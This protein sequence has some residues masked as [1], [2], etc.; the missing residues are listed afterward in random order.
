[1]LISAPLLFM[2]CV[3]IPPTENPIPIMTFVDPESLSKTLIIMLPGMGDRADNFVKA[4]FVDTGNRQHFDVFAVDAHSGYYTE[5]NLIPRLHEDIIV[6]AKASGYEN[7]WLLGVSM[8]GFGSLLYAEEYPDEIGG[9]I[10]LAPFLG[11]RQLI[12]GIEDAGGLSAWKDES[13]RFKQYE[14][15]IW[16]WLK[17]EITSSDGTPVILGFGHSDR[18]AEAYGLLVE[19]L[20]P[21]HVYISDGGHDWKTWETLWTRI[22]A[23][24]EM[25]PAN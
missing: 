18:M 14:V 5:R 16:T 8:G 23:N 2:S 9:V 3:T 12:E 7:I 25:P 1:M 4:G 22:A 24:I 6:P 11:S 17:T 13:K 15:D 10:L 21:S 19:A 20:D